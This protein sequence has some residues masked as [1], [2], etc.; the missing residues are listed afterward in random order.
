MIVQSNKFTQKVARDSMNSYVRMAETAK[1]LAEEANA[2]DEPESL[3]ALSER[4]N[5][6]RR[7]DH[8]NRMKYAD[9]AKK[10]VGFLES[11]VVNLLAQATFAAFPAADEEKARY[12]TSII[13]EATE[14]FASD[15][16]SVRGDNPILAQ[17][18]EEVFSLGD[19]FDPRMDIQ[20]SGF[21]EFVADSLNKELAEDGSDLQ[22]V[23]STLIEEVRSRI[24]AGVSVGRQQA[25]VVQSALEEQA[26]RIDRRELSEEA[27]TYSMNKLKKSM[28]PSLMETC[29][30]LVAKEAA[31]NGQPLS[32]AAVKE[33]MSSTAVL[34]MAIL[35]TAAAVEMFGMPIRL[36]DLAKRVM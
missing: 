11:M 30:V 16:C 29:Y 12:R 10:A 25:A 34:Y 19:A 8:S 24:I 7:H 9:N 17:L 5:P 26:A 22:M 32:E 36:T 2:T 1:Q 28:P 6:T 31:A 13:S 18:R 4:F 20:E 3:D 15:V 14:L 21:T 33:Q 23:M 35:E 27:A